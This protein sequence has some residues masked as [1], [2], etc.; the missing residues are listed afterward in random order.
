M[1]VTV[2]LP[3]YNNEKTLEIAIKS[4]LNQTLLDWELI[5]IDDGSADNSLIIAKKMADTDERIQLISDGQ[6]KGLIY[7]LNQII[8]IAQGNYIARMDADDIMLPERLEKQHA[9]FIGNAKIDI[10]ATAAFTIDENDNPIGIRDTDEIILKSKKDIFKK[11]L[12]I[13]PSI[14]VKRGWYKSNQYDKE[15]I[16]AEDFELWCRTFS[17]TTFYRITEPLLLYREGNVSIK[18]YT[19]SMKTLRMIYKKHSK[20]ILSDVEL[21]RAV[22]K[23]HLKSLIYQ[24]L[25]LFSLQYLL[26]SNRNNS[27]NSEQINYIKSTILKL[28]N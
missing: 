16:R 11:S 26:T 22:F 12:L 7:R 4:I 8:G 13:H 19:S 24:F 9:I 27:L 15:Y 23:T 20:G 25:G 28:K 6:N 18:N 17:H 5:L 1:K 10:V 2:G 3:F 21:E 14:L